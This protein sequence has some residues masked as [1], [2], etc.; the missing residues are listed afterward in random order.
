MVAVP[1]QSSH[2]SS[3]LRHQAGWRTYAIR[4]LIQKEAMASTLLSHI[5]ALILDMDG[6]LWQDNHP[7]LDMPVFFQALKSIHMP[8]VFATN[9]G[10]RSIAMYVERLAEFGV[11]VEP[12]QV[13]N[14]A[15][16][17]ANYLHKQYPDGGPVYVMAET[18]VL[19]A[20]VERGFYPLP[21]GAPSDAALAVVAGMDRSA[22]Y[23]KLSEAALL[24][25]AGKPFIFTNPDLTFP[26]PRGLVP[27][28][29]AFLAFL[30][31]A[32]GVPATI[33]G[34][35]EPYM[36]NFAMQRLG[37]SP[38]ETLAVG[39]RLDTDILGAQRAG[40]P[41]A[42]VL[43][44]VSTLAEAQAWQPQPELILPG[45]ADLLPLL[46]ESS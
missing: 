16:A 22:S 5:K 7:L 10:T 27:G 45:L 35:P 11:A 18:G 38:K 30:E 20:L 31:A 36:Y 6:V 40:C 33:I 32:T 39:D 29:G 15:I 37:T 17:A 12:W 28:A 19:E 9:N 1:P 23:A 8:V 13:V 25:R 26:T 43:S 34:K 3:D 4:P 14:S 41:S 42:L 24:I 2:R 44:G 46:L 21:P